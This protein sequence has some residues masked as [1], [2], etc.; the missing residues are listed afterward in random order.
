MRGYDDD[1][2]Y[3]YDRSDESADGLLEGEAFDGP[4]EQYPPF[5]DAPG[6]GQTYGSTVFDDT[7]HGDNTFTGDGW[8]ATSGAPYDGMDQSP[9]EAFEPSPRAYASL[10]DELGEEAQPYDSETDEPAT[11]MFGTAPAGGEAATE[12][13]ATAPA[14]GAA[15]AGGAHPSTGTHD[16]ATIDGDSLF[17]DEQTGGE[18]P[19]RGDLEDD[20]AET[21]WYRK[22]W[23]YAVAALSVI[24]L[25][26]AIA[27]PLFMNLSRAQEGDRLADEY[28]AAL[29][30][31]DSVWSNE[32][33]LALQNLNVTDPIGENGDFF[34]QSAA[35]M[36]AFAN[37]CTRVDAAATTLKE[38][39]G[40][41]LPTLAVREGADASE[42]Y[43]QAQQKSA[44]M[45][46]RAAKE[47]QL[48]KEGWVALTDLVEI[49]GTLPQYNSV[50][51]AYL[52]AQTE[53]LAPTLI[54][55]NNETKDIGNG[56]QWTCTSTAGCPNVLDNEN[57]I[58]YA[59][60][61]AASHQTFYRDFAALSQ[62]QCF[63]SKFQTVCDAYATNWS[64]A[65]DA[66]G[67]SVDSL[68]NTEPNVVEGAALVPESQQAEA[69]A[70]KAI[71]EGDNAVNAEWRKIDPSISDEEAG[72]RGWQA[73]SLKRILAEDQNTL[74][75][76]VAD[77]Q[78]ASG[79]QA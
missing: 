12:M 50:Y 38:L 26:A 52:N 68:K 30:Q 76:L 43:R 39:E 65:A 10:R 62:Q 40:A 1:P 2:Q 37:G 8:F 32:R 53:K 74:T 6:S 36:E 34:V 27:V 72:R 77:V 55:Q 33:L 29:T 22:P 60:A 7:L 18:E 25:I 9:T 79:Q 19:P 70:T 78:A 56:L 61:V 45:G 59:D 17:S 28:E 47:E 5:G 15:Y 51:N 13:F 20:R 67:R 3:P 54:V 31:H 69:D 57:R 73:R 24:L 23:F 42:R 75:Q 14:A 48:I 46:E 44:S 71:Q 41:A 4:T 21:P 66:Y 16:T 63:L 64:K 49:C 11:E 58:A 35:S